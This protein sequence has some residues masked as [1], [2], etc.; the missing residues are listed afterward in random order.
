MKKD[1]IWLIC[2]VAIL[3]F[4]ARDQFDNQS[5]LFIFQLMQSLG[6]IAIPILLFIWLK[7][8]EKQK[9]KQQELYEKQE[10]LDLLISIFPNL[11]YSERKNFQQK[12]IETYY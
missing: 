2:L 7:R 4:I 5:W 11:S 9:E 6:V 12:N 8:N 1:I 10:C 3:G